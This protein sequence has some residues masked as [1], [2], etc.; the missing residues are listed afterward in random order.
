MHVLVDQW[1]RHVH[2][3]CRDGSKELRRLGIQQDL[4][5]HLHLAV[6]LR[7]PQFVHWYHQRYIRE[8]EGLGSPSLHETTAIRPR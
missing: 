8:N 5:L 7:G 3:V 6:H 4:P 1:R 2:D